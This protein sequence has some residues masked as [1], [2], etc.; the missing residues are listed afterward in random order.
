M[1]VDG[2]QL[3]RI[4]GSISGV[5][6]AYP[7]FTAG[8]TTNIVVSQGSFSIAGQ[9]VTVTTTHSINA[10]LATITI[11][12]Q[13]VTVDRTRTISIGQA[14]VT[15]NGQAVTVDAVYVT[16]NNGILI[17]PLINELIFPLISEA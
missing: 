4:G 16:T 14:T 7:L 1:S 10:G 15:I 6:K 9:A 12:G 2:T 8:G 3:T 11:A 17:I 13:T 5:G